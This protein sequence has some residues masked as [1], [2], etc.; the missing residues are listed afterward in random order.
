MT[1]SSQKRTH[2]WNQ[3]VKEANRAKK[4]DFK[5][6]LQHKLSSDL[7]S[8]NSEARKA[9]SQAVKMSKKYS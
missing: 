7:Q 4:D 9:A 3:D 2:W 6:L 5:A 1:V 8:W